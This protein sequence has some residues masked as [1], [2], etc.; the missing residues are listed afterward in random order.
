[1]SAIADRS[2]PAMDGARQRVFLLPGLVHVTAV[3]TLITT[4]LGSCVAVCLW[5]RECGAGGM[6]HYLLPTPGPGGEPGPRY[7]DVAIDRLVEALAGLGCRKADMRASLF[8][9]ASVLAFATGGRTVGTANL[10]F[11]HERLRRHGIRAVEGQTGG[12]EGLFVEMD[13]GTGETMVRRLGV[14]PPATGIAPGRPGTTGR[15]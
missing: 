9:G 10:A 12:Q 15:S 1:M 7:G 13:T 6:N 5:D 8:G 4:I 2:D 14:C 11:A 3:P